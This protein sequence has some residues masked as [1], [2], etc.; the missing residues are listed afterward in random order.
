MESM[1]AEQSKEPC[2]RTARGRGCL[3]HRDQHIK[4]DEAGP[5]MRDE[6]TKREWRPRQAWET[7]TLQEMMQADFEQL[8]IRKQER[9]KKEYEK[10]IALA[11]KKMAAVIAA[12]HAAGKH[13]LCK[14]PGGG[15]FRKKN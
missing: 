15:C 9:E 13:V 7:Q 14:H 1:S 6:P 2:R 3:L 4:E 11:R 10:V 8:A 5:G 12:D